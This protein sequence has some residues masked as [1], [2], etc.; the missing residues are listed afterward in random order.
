MAEP[1][2]HQ[3]DIQSNLS[4]FTAAFKVKPLSHGIDYLAASLLVWADEIPVD[5]LPLLEFQRVYDAELPPEETDTA[6]I[7]IDA[8]T[9]RTDLV[10]RILCAVGGR[11]TAESH[12][13]RTGFHKLSR[14]ELRAVH[15]QLVDYLLSL[16]YPTAY[17]FWVDLLSAWIKSIPISLIEVPGTAFSIWIDRCINRLILHEEKPCPQQQVFTWLKYAVERWSAADAGL[18]EDG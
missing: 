2:P 11:L 7:F 10:D 5:K 1:P 6:E 3:P 9:V 14:D 17:Q 16:P 15:I 18:I 4:A 13:K 8:D 12:N